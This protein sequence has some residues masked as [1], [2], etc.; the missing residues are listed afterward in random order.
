VNATTDT[1]FSLSCTA[2]NLFRAGSAGHRYT[3][4]GMAAKPDRPAA[5]FSAQPSTPSPPASDEPTRAEHYGRLYL[6]RHRKDD[7]RALI[8]YRFDEDAPA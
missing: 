5:P 3:L 6:E 8:V 2:V 4:V 1:T 7:G